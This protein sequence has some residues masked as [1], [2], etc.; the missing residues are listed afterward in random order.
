M[1]RNSFVMFV[2]LMCVLI[3]HTQSP[4]DLKIENLMSAAEFRDAG[5]TKLSVG[6]L[7]H[8][9]S[10]LNSFTNQIASATAKET[11]KTPDVVESQIEGDF[12]GWDGETI[13]KLTNGQIWQQA[14]YDYTYE[15]A[16]RPSVTIFKTSGGYKMKVEDVEETIYVKRIK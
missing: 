12:K 11:L 2:I 9:N 14:E 15:Y 16:Y 13:F 10:W 5:P 7:N 1:S 3:G 6:E 8:L 4:A